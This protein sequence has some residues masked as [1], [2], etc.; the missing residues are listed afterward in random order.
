MSADTPKAV[1]EALCAAQAGLHHRARSGIDVDATAAW[2]DQIG[3]LIAAVDTHRPLAADGK[4]GEL[5]TD[6]C[7]CAGHRAAWS[8]EL[9]P[10]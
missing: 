7:G 9:L 2:L 3:T 5:H 8:I 4:H 6:T 1:R 10:G